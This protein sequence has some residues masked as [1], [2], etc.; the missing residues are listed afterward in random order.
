MTG[1]GSPSSDSLLNLLYR[2]LKL[3]LPY[4][5]LG[6]TR[7]ILLHDQAV[8]GVVP[9]WAVELHRRNISVQAIA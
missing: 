3:G 6:S 9:L 1:R 8:V 2:Y 4:R 5:A 7:P